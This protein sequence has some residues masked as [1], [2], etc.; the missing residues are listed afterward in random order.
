[1][2]ALRACAL[3][4]LELTAVAAIAPSHGAKD[5]LTARLE[6]LATKVSSIAATGIKQEPAQDAEPERDVGALGRKKKKKKKGG[7]NKCKGGKKK[8]GGGKKKKGGGGGGGKGKCCPFTRSCDPVRECMKAGGGKIPHGCKMGCGFGM[9]S[10]MVYAA[11]ADVNVSAASD[12]A[13]A[14]DEIDETGEEDEEEQVQAAEA[15]DHDV[16]AEAEAEE[17]CKKGGNKG[18]KKGGK[19]KGRKK[20]GGKKK[21]GKKKKGGGGGGGKGKCCPFTRSCDPVR[22]CMKAGGGKIPHGCKMGCGFGSKYVAAMGA[23]DASD[24][25]EAFAAEQKARH[26]I[27]DTPLDASED[28]NEDEEG[29]DEEE[30]GGEGAED[31]DEEEEEEEGEEEEGGGDE[32]GD[33]EAA[34]EDA[35]DEEDEDEGEDEEDEDEDEDDDGA[36]E[37]EEEAESDEQ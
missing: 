37:E 29:V 23:T 3:L 2:V 24:G 14:V 30:D 33:D 7:K 9:E 11:A 10:K 28:G 36:E 5:T 19:K 32:A 20:K 27:L 34:N 25:Y 15:N 22:E 31:D 1:M 16:D 17:E 4:L 6:S 12:D 13:A 8:K 21:G 18:K 26:A 35:L